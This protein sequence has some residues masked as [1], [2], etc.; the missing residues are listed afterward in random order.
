MFE[1]FKRKPL[2]EKD[3]KDFTKTESSTNW[4]TID[5]SC[6]RCDKE[7][8]HTEFMSDICNNCG[9][10]NTVVRHQKVY[11]KIYYQGKWVYQIKYKKLGEFISDKLVDPNRLKT[12]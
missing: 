5:I 8:Y 1:F 4:N 6:N 9:G 12:E 11:R 10:I 3:P 7:C 2:E